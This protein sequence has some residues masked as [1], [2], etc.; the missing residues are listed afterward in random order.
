[1][2]VNMFRM[3][4]GAKDVMRFTRQFSGRKTPPLPRM[5]DYT[6]IV[7]NIKPCT[8]IISAVE[9]AYE[10][11]SKGEVE[12]PSALRVGILDRDVSFALILGKF[13]AL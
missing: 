13:Y 7:E 8:E 6:S 10:K 1:M 2:K 9:S 11:V 4:N 12:N 5:F 3:S